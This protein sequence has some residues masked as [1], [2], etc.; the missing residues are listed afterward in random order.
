[1]ITSKSWKEETKPADQSDYF[2]LTPLYETFR[3]LHD[4][5]SRAANYGSEFWLNLAMEA[6]IEEN[7]RKH[8][9]ENEM[10]GEI[11]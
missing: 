3:V 11:R 8:C 9:P 10:A 1:L 5:A 2:K 4:M 6:V 7:A